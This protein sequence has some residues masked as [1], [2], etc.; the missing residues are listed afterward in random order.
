LLSSSSS[1][2]YL[3]NCLIWGEILCSIIMRNFR[4]FPIC[5]FTELFCVIWS[6]FLLLFF[7]CS[8]YVS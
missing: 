4:P 6:C 1:S 2:L 7:S 8:R 3:L 5:W